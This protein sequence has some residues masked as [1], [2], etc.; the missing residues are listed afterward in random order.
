MGSLTNTSRK[1]TP[2]GAGWLE[3]PSVWSGGKSHFW[4]RRNPDTDAREWYMWDRVK[5]QWTFKE[6]KV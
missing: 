4:F 1:G 2:Q 3:M 5:R 6:D